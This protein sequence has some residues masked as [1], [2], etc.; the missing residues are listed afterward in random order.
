MANRN[1]AKGDR[2]ERAVRDWAESLYPGSFKTRAG[3]NDDLGDIIL[4]HPGGRVVLQVKDVAS[5]AWTEWFAQLAGQVLTCTAESPVTRPTLGGVIVHKARGQA[6]PARWRAVAPLEAIMDLVDTAYSAGRA[7]GRL[8]AVE[9]AR[10]DADR[11]PRFGEPPEPGT[12]H[13]Q[14]GYT[15]N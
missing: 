6:D 14:G 8:D 2:A 11:P 12:T 13:R 9:D 10:V 1:K 4:E 7:Q 5:P 15:V 3:F